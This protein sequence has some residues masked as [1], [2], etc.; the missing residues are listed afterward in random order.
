MIGSYRIDT[1]MLQI[2]SELIKVTETK[3]SSTISKHIKNYLFFFKLIYISILKKSIQTYQ[4]TC[5]V[6]GNSKNPK[7]F[8]L[9]NC[10]TSHQNYAHGYFPICNVLKNN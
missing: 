3:I 6:S 8:P 9:T 10:K 7:S 1:T 4:L 2:H 5:S